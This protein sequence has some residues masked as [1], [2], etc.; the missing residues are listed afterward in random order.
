[1]SNEVKYHSGIKYE[2]FVGIKDKDT[3][4]EKLTVED[5]TNILKE[6]CTERELSFSMLTQFG[7]YPHNK[8]YT[9]ENS[10]RVA[11]IGADEG[12]V[13]RLGQL[14]KER[15]NTDTVMITKTQVEFAYV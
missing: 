5:F 12:E 2:I 1:M 6:I 3:Y 10:L 13:Q 4:E 7:G 9:T 11:I 14:L 15:I 8:G